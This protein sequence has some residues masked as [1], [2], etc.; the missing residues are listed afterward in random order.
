MTQKK[1]LAAWILAAL[2]GLP[3]GAAAHIRVTSSTPASGSTSGAPVREVRLTFSQRVGPQFTRIS[4]IGP[5][6]AEMPLVGIAPT[7]S[8][9]R[10]FVATLAGHWAPA[11]TPCAGARPEPMVM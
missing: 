3:N 7:D 11:T 8:T 2:F 10:E 1:L 5:S 4:I 6:G 9:Q